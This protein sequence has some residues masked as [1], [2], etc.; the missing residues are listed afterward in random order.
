MINKEVFYPESAFGGFTDIDGSIAFY[1]RVNSLLKPEF[2]L[3]DVGCGRG[4]YQDDLVKSRSSLRIFKDKVSRVIGIDVDA[5]GADNPFLDEFHLIQG[6]AW[7]LE[8]ESV[9]FIVCDWVL[10]HISDADLFF[11]EVNRVLKPGGYFCARTTNRWHYFAIGASL[12]PNKLHAKVVGYVQ[13]SR[14][15][16]DVFP[17]VYKCNTRS[18]LKKLLNGHNFK[19]TVYTYEAEPS[20]LSFSR[21]S[22]FLGTV[23]QKFAPSFLK[24]A[25]FV[26]A[27]KEK[28][29]K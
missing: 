18:S 12:I 3:L 23:Y 5:A 15:A 6:D 27:Q 24:A 25:I 26:F 7:A 20:Y 13:S 21:I 8:D 10:E 1:F 29:P 22:Y 4:E 17:T 16:E 28:L 9:D 11:S 2:V 14:R 19:S